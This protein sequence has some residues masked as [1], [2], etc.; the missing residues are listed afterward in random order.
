ME[1]LASLLKKKK[2]IKNWVQY[3]QKKERKHPDSL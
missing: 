3:S 1:Y 2:K